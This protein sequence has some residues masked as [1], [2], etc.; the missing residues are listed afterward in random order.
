MGFGTA[1]AAAAGAGVPMA[2]MILSSSR[3]PSAAASSVKGALSPMALA[4]SRRP[5]S[6]ADAVGISGAPVVSGAGAVVSS[7]ESIFW[8]WA[9]RIFRYIRPLQCW[10]LGPE[11]VPSAPSSCR[12]Y[13]APAAAFCPAAATGCL[14]LHLHR[15]PRMH[16]AGRAGMRISCIHHVERVQ[17]HSSRAAL[18]MRYKQGA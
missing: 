18:A 5:G 3:R 1:G 6:L 4:S 17:L 9:S 10:W 2:V 11:Q 8:I 15:Q 16:T 12:D 14:A 7:E 13:V